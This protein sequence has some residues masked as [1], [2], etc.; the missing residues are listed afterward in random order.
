[1]IRRLLPAAF[2]LLALPRPVLADD[3]VELVVAVD[4]ISTALAK[5]ELDRASQAADQALMQLECQPEPVSPLVLA[6]LFQLAGAVAQ[7][8]GSPAKAEQAFARAVAISP[9]AAV[10][11][12][13]GEAVHDVYAQ[14]QRRVLSELGGSLTI[15]GDVQ[16]WLD[17]RSIQT[18]Q[19]MDVIVGTHLLQY[20]EGELAL[21]GREIRVSSGESRTL[22]LGA[23]SAV[24]PVVLEPEPVVPA[25]PVGSGGPNKGLLIGGGAGVAVG[26][27]LLGVAASTQ[28]SFYRATDAADLED[29][30]RR[31]HSFV[32]AGA[33][34]GAVGASLMGVSFLV[35]GSPGVQLRWRW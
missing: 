6:G 26:A 7:F 16:V 27:V 20:R 11:A 22:T 8:N 15:Q 10:D 33:G 18:N 24:P 13:Y 4:E 1:M 12:I 21:Q 2:V 28:V 30:Y 17:G 23:V 9:T 34:V 19:P 25:G 35:D 3:C 32:L 14:V 5:V 31:N 29:L